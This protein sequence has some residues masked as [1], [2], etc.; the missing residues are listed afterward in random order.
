L[1]KTVKPARHWNQFASAL[2]RRNQHDPAA[3]SGPFPFVSL[4][5]GTEISQAGCTK[6]GEHQDRYPHSCGA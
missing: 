5:W 4:I 6:S 3:D 1:E 2:G